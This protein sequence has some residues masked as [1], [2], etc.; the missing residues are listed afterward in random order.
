MEGTSKAESASDASAWHA[1][2]ARQVT[3]GLTTDTK[4]GL[5]ASEA[6]R[7][8]SQFNNVLVYVLLGAGFVKLMLN[9][10]IDTATAAA[11]DG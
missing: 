8:L 9:L 1:M 5:N 7:F 10:W 3:E 2:T 6:C 4:K 11:I